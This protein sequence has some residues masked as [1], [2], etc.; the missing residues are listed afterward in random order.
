MFLPSALKW[1]GNYVGKGN[2]FKQILTRYWL[3]RL[4]FAG[5]RFKGACPRPNHGA[6]HSN[7][8]CCWFQ[9]GNACSDVAIASPLRI[10]PPSFLDDR[11]CLAD[12]SVVGI[13]SSRRHLG[14]PFIWAQCRFESAV[15]LPTFSQEIHIHV[16]LMSLAL[17]RCSV[18]Y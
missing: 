11:A 14:S 3:P 18:S 17:S 5:V 10:Q 2:I 7:T 15:K 8:I 16:S 13:L 6:L 1:K 4:L 9:R 12:C